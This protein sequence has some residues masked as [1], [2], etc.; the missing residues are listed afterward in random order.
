MKWHL[1]F[2]IISFLLF[3]G[4]SGDEQKELPT[5]DVYEIK[6]VGLLSTTEYTIG[7]IIKLNDASNL[8]YKPGNRK[9][10]IRCKAKIKAGVDLSK[11]TDDDIVVTGNKITIQLPP[12]EITSF[13]MDPNQVHTQMES[14][15]KF[16]DKFTQTEKNNLMRQGEDAIRK[17]I[18]E[19]GIHK[20]A[21][22]NA[23]KFIEEFYS[24][25]GF[26]EVEVI[27]HSEAEERKKD[28]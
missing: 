15:T 1:I 8:W 13:T 14:T 16:R 5:T 24:Q 4:C 2:S 17:D 7:K 26:T 28:E 18:E 20:D 27:S 23:I 9:I 25:L 12:S 19:T 10:L 11:I 3:S 21:E 22:D 6:N